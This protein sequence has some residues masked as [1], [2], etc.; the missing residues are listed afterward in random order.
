MPTPLAVGGIGLGARLAGDIFGGSGGLPEWY[1]D[2]IRGEVERDRTSGFLPDREVFDEALQSQLAG[3]T[4]Q[5]PAS[6]EAFNADAAARGVFSS[7]QAGAEL[8]RTAIAPI[9]RAGTTAIA[10]ANLGFAQAEQRGRIAADTS[11]QNYLALLGQALSG[12]T[13]TGQRI[14]GTLGELGDFGIQYG[15]LGALG[16]FDEGT[17]LDLFNFGEQVPV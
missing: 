14:A 13:S 3:F 4:A 10:Q 2:L 5:L 11:R 1:I 8:Y 12:Q 15:T 17:D 6:V 9:A 7:G 16:F